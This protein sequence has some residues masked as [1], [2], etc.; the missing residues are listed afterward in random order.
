MLKKW[1]SQITQ[2]SRSTVKKVAA[3]FYLVAGKQYSVL[4]DYY[5]KWIKLFETNEKTS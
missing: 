2:Y 5:T 4:A 3:D 1:A